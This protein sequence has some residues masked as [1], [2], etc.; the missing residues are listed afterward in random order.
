VDS[1][2]TNPTRASSTYERRINFARIFVAIAFGICGAGVVV[3]TNSIERNATIP[4]MPPAW[5]YVAVAFAVGMLV[6]LGLTLAL[7]IEGIF[8]FC[9]NLLGGRFQFSLLTLLV[10]MTLL[11][12]LSGLFASIMSLPT[13]RQ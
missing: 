12:V 4:G 7:V 5:G 10:I 9:I 6:C 3:S 1:T 8:R 11:A 2:P 13:H